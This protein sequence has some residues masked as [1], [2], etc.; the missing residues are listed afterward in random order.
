VVSAHGRPAIRVATLRA[1]NQHTS[2]L[3]SVMWLALSLVRGQLRPGAK[4]PGGS[5]KASTSLTAAEQHTVAAAFNGG[6]RLYNDS[7]HG[8]YYSEGRTAVPLVNN[9]ASLVLRTDVTATV[10]SWNKD[11]RMNAQ[12][13]SVL[14][15]MVMLVDNGNVNP[16][17]QSGGTAQ[18]GSTIS[19]A[20]YIDRSGFGV[21]ADGAEVYVGGP[22][23]SVCTLGR[24]MADAGVGRGMELDINP[25]WVSGDV[26]PR[27]ASRVTPGIPALPRPAG[28]VRALPLSLQPRLVRVV[29][30]AL[31]PPWT[32]LSTHR[33]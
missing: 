4:D 18:W 6:F 10:S 27:R 8:G 17:C 11:V 26:L 21:T 28:A 3:A 14:Q 23:M 12:V 5:W 33:D 13:A 16:T 29:H 19:Q 31:T 20:V 2:Y 22:A 15:N 24:L 32:A 1:D 9:A 25:A 7:S 30:P